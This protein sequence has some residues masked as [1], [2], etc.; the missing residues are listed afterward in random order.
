MVI[1]M[2]VSGISASKEVKKNQQRALMILESI[3]VPFESIDITEPGKEEDRDFMKEHCKKVD[4]VCTLPPHFF[5]EKEYCGDYED[6]DQATEED[7]LIL[8][9]KLD[10]SE[11]NL[12]G[13][14]IV[15]EG[16]EPIVMPGDK[17]EGET[18]SGMVNGA[19]E[20]GAH[21][22]GT[23][24]RDENMDVGDD[25]KEQK[26][27]GGTEEGDAEEK[28]KADEGAENVEEE[29]QE[30]VE[31]DEGGTGGDEVEG[32]G[33]EEEENEG[34][35]ND[36]REEK[37]DDDEMKADDEVTEEQSGDKEDMV[38]VEEEKEE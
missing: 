28:G 22:G 35:P 19:R 7:R 9:L 13:S 2:Y 29:K 24:D 36:E 30:D 10:P 6:F 23:G 37:A 25:S 33:D 1:K 3:K 26:P 38:D 4:G 27:E 11:Y 20:E 14:S 5:N 21:E 17:G 34:A 12:N 18:E 32:K 15:P 16:V 31:K 8:F